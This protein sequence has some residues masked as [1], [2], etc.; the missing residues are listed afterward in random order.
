[1]NEK[2]EVICI[3]KSIPS[4]T[5]LV[6]KERI[7]GDGTVEGIRLKFYVGQ[8][9]KLRVMPKILQTGDVLFDLATYPE[10]T[11]RF[12]SG[13]DDLVE[14]PCIISVGYDDELQIHVENTDAANSYSLVCDVFIDYFGGKSRLL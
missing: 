13:D 6:I 7:K 1:M 4:N 9:K 3:R 5:S 10:G 11:D 12:L 8:E 2:K 14:I